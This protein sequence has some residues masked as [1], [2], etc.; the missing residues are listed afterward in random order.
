M[1]ANKQ[2]PKWLQ[3]II[4]SFSFKSPGLSFLTKL[5]ISLPAPILSVSAVIIHQ[6]YIKYYTDVL[7]LNASLVGLVYVIYNIWNAINDP[8]I[9]A[10]V[11]RQPYRPKHGK[12]VYLLH[13][14]VPFMMLM[15]LAMAFTQPSWS[16]WV[17]FGVFLAELFIFDTAATAYGI[18]YGAYVQ[19]A[20]PTKEERLDIGTI[21]NYLTYAMSFL[22]A[23]IPTLLL[24]RG[25]D[26]QLF[27]PVLCAVVAVQTVIFVLALRGLKDTPEMYKTVQPAKRNN[28]VAAKEAWHII[29]S[30]PFLASVSYSVLAMGA[31]QY[32]STA[33]LYYMDAVIH[34]KG[35]TATLIGFVTHLVA[36]A[37]MPVMNYVVKRWGTKTNV[38]IG[39]IPATIGYLGLTFAH[40]IGEVYLYYGLVVFCTIYFGTAVAPM[41]ALIIDEDEWQT[42][43]RKTGLYNGLFG[44]FTTSLGSL[45]MILYT[46]IMS[47]TG[48]RGQAAVQTVRAENGIRFATG[49]LPLICIWVGLI[50]IIVYPYSRQKER[51]ISAES[52]RMRAGEPSPALQKLRAAGQAPKP[53]E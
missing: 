25:G 3:V 8:L 26:K 32:Y 6:V 12:Y 44:I 31:L 18:A 21:G 49:I 47:A 28:K 23:M 17:K 42:G 46:S 16:Q 14:T 24:F 39:M 50:A 4:D 45:Q 53:E 33:Y 2:R 9:G 27:I 22:A 1:P 10:L 36:L 35:T 20:A 51:E 52:R 30:R 19:I 37:L 41:N 11:D 7:G 48:Y 29:K 15:T 43:V 13:V 34:A 40:T 38:M 5:K